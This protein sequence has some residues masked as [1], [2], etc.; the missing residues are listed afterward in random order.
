MGGIPAGRVDPDG[1]AGLGEGSCA[2]EIANLQP[3]PEADGAA[4]DVEGADIG[5]AAGRARSDGEVSERRVS[6]RLRHRPLG[7]IGFALRER[8]VVDGECARPDLGKRPVRGVVT[9]VG[10]IDRAGEGSVCVV[11]AYREIIGS[12]VHRAGT[13][14]G[15]YGLIETV[16]FRV[17]PVPTVN[18]LADE[19]ALAAPACSV[20]AP[21][22]VAPE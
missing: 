13:G 1:A 6:T 16:E 14:E 2:A 10:H 15:S 17:A 11:A 7:D 18:A 22:L 3:R 20:P 19:K 4:R 21:I 12:H 8:G 9:L 5:N